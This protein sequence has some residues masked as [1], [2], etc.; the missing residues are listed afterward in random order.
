M[1]IGLLLQRIL[2]PRRMKLS[3]S[4]ATQS[5]DTQLTIMTVLYDKCEGLIGLLLQV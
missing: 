3:D 5:A 1:L 4:Y 2:Q